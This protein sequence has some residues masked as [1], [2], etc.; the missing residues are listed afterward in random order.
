M[1]I[2]STFVYKVHGCCIYHFFCFY[3]SH[4]CLANCHIRLSMMQHERKLI[5][6]TL[7]KLCV[8]FCNEYVGP[9]F[10]LTVGCRVV[11]AN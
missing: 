4:L 8:E 5:R 2:S 7:M 10:M 11:N 1:F 3:R 6:P 9:P